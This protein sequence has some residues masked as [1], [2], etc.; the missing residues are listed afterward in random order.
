MQDG[1]EGKPT[2]RGFYRLKKERQEEWR[3]A[4]YLA[5]RGLQ[6]VPN[7]AAAGALRLE[8]PL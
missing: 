2:N 6:G 4:D 5:G 3:E 1:V 8:A 7:W